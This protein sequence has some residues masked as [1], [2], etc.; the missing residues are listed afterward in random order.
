MCA[1]Q[2]LLLSRHLIDQEQIKQLKAREEASDQP[3][4]PTAALMVTWFEPSSSKRHVLDNPRPRGEMS[5]CSAI[6]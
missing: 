3:P 4:F 6:R 1:S 2:S 5:I